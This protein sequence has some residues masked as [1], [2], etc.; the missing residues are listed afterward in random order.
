MPA[1]KRRPGPDEDPVAFYLKEYEWEMRPAKAD[2]ERPPIGSTVVAWVEKERRE[3]SQEEVSAK[4]GYRY[5]RLPV[6][7]LRALP[8]SDRDQRV[9]C[10][11]SMWASGMRW[12]D[13]ADV[14][15]VPLGEIR[16]AAEAC[17]WAAQ[18]FEARQK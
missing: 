12:P 4:D 15:R 18:R 16:P 3:R 7:P 5:A 2:I 13:I 11:V 14:V 10:A 8:K 17:R 6:E 1:T 9:A